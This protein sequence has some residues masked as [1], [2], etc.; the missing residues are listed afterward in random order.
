[1]ER[2]MLDLHPGDRRPSKEIRKRSKVTDVVEKRCKL[3]LTREIIETTTEAVGVL[4]HRTYSEFKLDGKNPKVKRMDR[5]ST[6]IAI[7]VD[8][9]GINPTIDIIPVYDGD[10]KNC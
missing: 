2:R 4:W 7:K 5:F 9:G 10:W 8:D 6:R 1:M 3:R